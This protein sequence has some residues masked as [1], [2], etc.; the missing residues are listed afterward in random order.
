MIEMLDAKRA[1]VN[2][3]NPNFLPL[4]TLFPVTR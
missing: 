4:E 2:I 3:S 1:V